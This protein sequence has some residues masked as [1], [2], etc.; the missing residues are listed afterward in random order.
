MAI[1]GEQKDSV[2]NC[3]YSLP[4]YDVE[5]FDPAA[6]V[7]IRQRS[8]LESKFRFDAEALDGRVYV[9]GGQQAVSRDVLAVSATVEVFTPRDLQDAAPLP[10]PVPVLVLVL[11]ALVTRIVPDCVG[12]LLN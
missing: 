10:L 11:G 12:A 7:W 5:T 2:V 6:N 1:G 4:V 8:L 9:F 3:S